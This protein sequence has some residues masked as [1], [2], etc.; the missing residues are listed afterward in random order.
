MT[1]NKSGKMPR[2]R[3]T[4][5]VQLMAWA[6]SD[7]MARLNEWDK[8]SSKHGKYLYELQENIANAVISGELRVRSQTT[9]MYMAASYQA[10]EDGILDLNDFCQWAKKYGLDA[11]DDAAALA[12]ALGMPLEAFPPGHTGAQ[13]VPVIEPVTPIAVSL[14]TNDKQAE[15]MVK[16]VEIADAIGRRK[17]IDGEREITARNICKAVATELAKGEPGNPQKYH[18]NRGQR[19]AGSI[20]NAALRGWKFTVPSGT[21]GIN[22]TDKTSQENMPQ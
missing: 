13:A 10:Y 4:I 8:S 7:V 22:G 6:Y 15:W 5:K 14:K 2:A 17:W 9:K 12:V 21:S 20:R 18:G 11:P 3:W 1:E 19:A 16:S